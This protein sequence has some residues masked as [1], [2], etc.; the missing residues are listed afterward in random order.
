M[1]TA[2]RVELFT[3][4][5]LFLRCRQGMQVL[6]KESEMEQVMELIA[7][8]SFTNACFQVVNYSLV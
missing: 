6:I 5:T 8:N 2:S 4:F 3:T 7:P 1:L